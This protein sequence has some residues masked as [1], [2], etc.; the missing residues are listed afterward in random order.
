M[1]WNPTS[2]LD[3]MLA[4]LQFGHLNSEEQDINSVIQVN[5]VNR[6][7]PDYYTCFLC[8]IFP[9]LSML[10][11]SWYVFLWLDNLA[12]DSS[13]NNINSDSDNNYVLGSAPEITASSKRFLSKTQYF[14]AGILIAA[15]GLELLP[16]LV[17]D[18]TKNLTVLTD[19]GSCI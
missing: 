9:T 14:S 10:S 17:Q 7:S 3:T 19:A 1:T 16:K 15:I 5:E 13:V 8:T 2:I 18:S 6:I 4:Q 11:G 12:T